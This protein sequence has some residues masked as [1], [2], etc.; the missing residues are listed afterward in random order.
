MWAAQLKA[1]TVEVINYLRDESDK[2]TDDYEKSTSS[3]GISEAI[4]RTIM[5]QLR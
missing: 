2:I 3:A 1:R 5:F 4:K